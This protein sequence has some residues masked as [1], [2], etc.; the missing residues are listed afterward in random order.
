MLYLK[1]HDYKKEML[2][3]FKKGGDFCHERTSRE[4][5]YYKSFERK[6]K[7]Y[8]ATAKVFQTHK[9]SLHP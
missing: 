7:N 1:I 3:V 5:L 4:F 9:I 6:N 2:I 8:N